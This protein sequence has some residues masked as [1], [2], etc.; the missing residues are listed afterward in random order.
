[1]DQQREAGELADK[2]DHLWLH[3]RTLHPAARKGRK[4]LH[5]HTNLGDQHLASE[6]RDLGR[7]RAH[8]AQALQQLDKKVEINAFIN[9]SHNSLEEY[10]DYITETTQLDKKQPGMIP[11]LIS[12]IVDNIQLNISIV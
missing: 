10:E 4:D 2:A 12:K 9:K 1:M 6:D 8:Q 7:I 11:N 3:A 5:R